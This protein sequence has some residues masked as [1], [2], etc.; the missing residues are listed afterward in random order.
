MRP[1]DDPEVAAWLGKA[2]DDLE[3]A[4]ALATHTPHLEAIICFHYQQAAE[5]QLKALLVAAERAVPRTQDLDLLVREI[6]PDLAEIRS[7]RDSATLL[8]GYA[9]LPR[10]P[11]FAAVGSTGALV[12]EARTAVDSI[13]AV[14]E[15]A[16]G[17]NLGRPPRIPDQPH[18]A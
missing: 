8:K 12:R 16:L 11:T 4:A 14:V 9:V 17:A 18:G 7:I 3:A 6:E 13:A 2:R 10:Y 5:K 15:R 1:P